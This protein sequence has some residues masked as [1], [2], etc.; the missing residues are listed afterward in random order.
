MKGYS[1][2]ES[3]KDKLTNEYN[4]LYGFNLK[5]KEE[6]VFRN[7]IKPKYSDGLKNNRI[8]LSKN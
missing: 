8:N 6:D 3:A 4:N 5:D 7:Y 1:M 2:D